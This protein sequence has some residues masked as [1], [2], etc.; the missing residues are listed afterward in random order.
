MKF[1][2]SNFL[3]I[4]ILAISYS[5]PSLSDDLFEEASDELKEL[6]ERQNHE[7]LIK[8]LYWTKNHKFLILNADTMDDD[9]IEI[10]FFDDESIEFELKERRDRQYGIVWNG[11]SEDLKENYYETLDIESLAQNDKEVFQRLADSHSNIRIYTGII[12]EFQDGGGNFYYIDKQSDW[13]DNV[14]LTIASNNNPREFTI[15]NVRFTDL[16]TNKKYSIKHLKNTPSVH[17][18]TEIDQEKSQYSRLDQPARNARDKQVE[19]S[20]EEYFRYLRKNGLEHLTIAPDPEELRRQHYESM[21]QNLMRTENAT[22][23]ARSY[24][25]LRNMAGT[26]E[27]SLTLEEIEQIIK[28]VDEHYKNRNEQLDNNGQ[29]N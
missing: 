24:A 21:K 12:Q 27:D 25:V 10:S 18:L 28:E 22:R 23:R 4:F 17:L 3:V 7:Y 15:A 16:L 8:Q 20:Q 14:D 19:K 1:I 29:G 2:S 6:A 11:E 5:P 26:T 13:R 9:E